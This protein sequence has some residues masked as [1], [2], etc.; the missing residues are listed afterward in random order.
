MWIIIVNDCILVFIINNYY[1]SYNSEIFFNKRLYV[2]MQKSFLRT[3][4]SFVWK[5]LLAMLYFLIYNFENL[6]GTDHPDKQSNDDE[7]NNSSC[8][9]SSDVCEFW[10]VFTMRSNEWSNTTTRWLASR[11]LHTCSLVFT[12]TSTHIWE[13]LIE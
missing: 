1:F 4:K 10:L 6:P 9:S 3:V 5:F 2:S 12:E 13:K 8:N 11:V 7:E